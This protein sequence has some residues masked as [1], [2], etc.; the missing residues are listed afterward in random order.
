LPAGAAGA[1][2]APAA[3]RGLPPVQAVCPPPPDPSANR[4][5]PAPAEGTRAF[6]PVPVVDPPPATAASH[7]V[8][9]FAV[10]SAVANQPHRPRRRLWQRLQP[11]APPKRPRPEPPAR[12]PAAAIQLRCRRPPNHRRTEPWCASRPCAVFP[13]QRDGRPASRLPSLEDRRRPFPPRRRRRSASRRPWPK[14]PERRDGWWEGQA[15]RGRACCNW[16]VETRRRG[17]ASDR[18]TAGTG[19]RRGDREIGRAGCPR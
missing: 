8:P 3:C 17:S 4:R 13:G 14:P 10:L 6:R 1:K 2:N 5:L 11:L 9:A 7:L 12:L 15:C 18:R 16:L 19:G